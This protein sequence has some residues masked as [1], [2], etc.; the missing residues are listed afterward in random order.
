[1]LCTTTTSYC[2]V[3]CEI[4]Y[5]KFTKELQ[6]TVKIAIITKSKYTSAISKA[7]REEKNETAFE[8]DEKC[9]YKKG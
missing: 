1:M 2:L 9:M 7:N 8:K 3:I 5:I 4:S 6:E